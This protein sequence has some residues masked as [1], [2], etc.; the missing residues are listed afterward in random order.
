MLLLAIAIT[1]TACSSP[2]GAGESDDVNSEAADVGDEPSANEIYGLKA[3]LHTCQSTGKPDA[4][5]TITVWLKVGITAPEILDIDTLLAAA[6]AN[7]EGIDGYEFFDRD[8]TLD[9]FREFFADEPQL[10]GLV[11][12]DQLPMSFDVEVSNFAEAEGL[13]DDL[14]QQPTVDAVEIRV[15]PT[16]C[17]AE[18][19][20][21]DKACRR[22][23]ESPQE[24][25]V[26]LDPGVDPADVAT[27]EDQLRAHP[28]VM[29]L[30][31]VDIDET[32][33]DFVDMFPDDQELLDPDKLPT[34]FVVTVTPREIDEYSLLRVET[35]NLSPVIESADFGGAIGL[36]IQ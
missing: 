34:R 10:G 27:V 20:A 11:D 17:L 5:A 31:Y 2:F 7:G 16:M 6:K 30:R 28:A 15:D 1:A 13:I 22:F 3:K 29:D 14:D 36:C 24:L 35:K 32:Y 26:W 12:P 19:A 8:K 23:S 9:R 33:A 25:D 21:V 4:P 18:S